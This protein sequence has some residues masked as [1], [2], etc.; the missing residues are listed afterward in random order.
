MIDGDAGRPGVEEL[1]RKVDRG[2]RDD[3]AVEES[4]RSRRERLGGRDDDASLLVV[5]EESILA[6]G[7][8]AGRAVAAR[9]RGGR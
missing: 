3:G 7:K 5:E 2:E 4:E 8:A 1:R 9:V 6:R